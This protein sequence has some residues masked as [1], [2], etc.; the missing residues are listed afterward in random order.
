[1]KLKVKSVYGRQLFYP[2]NEEADGVVGLCGK[3]TLTLSDL[4][5]LKWLGFMI[6]LVPDTFE[7]DC[8]DD[9]T[10]MKVSGT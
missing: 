4:E 10:K 6:E 1:M 5:L 3:R 2:M 7:I 8:L 9:K